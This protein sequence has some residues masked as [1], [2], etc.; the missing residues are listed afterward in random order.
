MSVRILTVGD[1][2]YSEEYLFVANRQLV[3]TVLHKLAP[4]YKAPRDGEMPSKVVIHEDEISLTHRSDEEAGMCEPLFNGAC[5]METL[6][7]SEDFELLE[8]FGEA[9]LP[10][11]AAARDLPCITFIVLYFMCCGAPVKDKEPE[12]VEEESDGEDGKEDEEDT[13]FEVGVEV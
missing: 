1:F 10:D 12:T 6:T 11:H 13:H 5:A 9:V 8:V 4:K 2:L 7:H 3:Q